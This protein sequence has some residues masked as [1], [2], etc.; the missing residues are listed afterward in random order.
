MLLDHGIHE[1][2]IIR[3]S[4]IINSLLIGNTLKYLQVARITQR[5]ISMALS[6]QSISYFQVKRDLNK[7]VDRRENV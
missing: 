7:K 5:E 1:V 2:S 6:F 3:E 4:T